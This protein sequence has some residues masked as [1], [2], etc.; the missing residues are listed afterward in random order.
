MTLK[1]LQRILFPVLYPLSWV[2]GAV[3][4]FRNFL[5]DKG[6]LKSIQFDLNVICVGNLTAGGTGKTPF[7]KYLIELLKEEH[8]IAVLSRGYKRT[9]KGFLFAEE[10]T[11]PNEIGDE[12]MM[13]WNHY[14]K[15]IAVAVGEDRVLA[16][17]QIL[18]LKE[19]CDTIILD[20]AFQHRYVKP[21]YSI[22][23]TD[24]SNLFTKDHLLPYG[25]LREPRFNAKRAQV[26]VV[27]KG[28]PS[29]SNTEKEAIKNEVL[30]YSPNAQVFFSYVAYKQEV[31]S[32]INRKPIIAFSGIAQNITFQNHLKSSYTVLETLSFADHHW[33]TVADV[34]RIVSL[35][36]QHEALNPVLVTTEKDFMRLQDEK[37]QHIIEGLPLCYIPISVEFLEDEQQFVD[38]LKQHL[39]K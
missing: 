9:T 10:S 23:L 3:A 39:K 17:P 16:I 31:G 11:K 4:M 20:D 22:L 6:V 25:L 12:P 1:T 14:K 38:T 37:L 8:Q 5:F 24:Y 28:P 13:Y 33:Y 36:K 2:Y 29:L 26:I 32:A 30:H 27:T 21:S 35:Y 7:V 34:Q 15:E 19:N 18:Q